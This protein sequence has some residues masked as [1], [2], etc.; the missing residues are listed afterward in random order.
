MNHND[1]TQSTNWNN[2]DVEPISD[3]LAFTAPSEDFDIDVLAGLR[4]A[5][6]DV[7]AG[8]VHPYSKLRELLDE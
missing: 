7:K 4:R 3:V 6:E 1:S 5:L 8:R 2:S